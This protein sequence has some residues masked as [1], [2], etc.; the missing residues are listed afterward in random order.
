MCDPSQI[1]HFFDHFHWFFSIFLV[2][3]PVQ[4]CEEIHNIL[5]EADYRR[6]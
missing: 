1:D 6:K 4:K 3:F 2:S 5:L